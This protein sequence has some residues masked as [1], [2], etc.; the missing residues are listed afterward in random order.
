MHGYAELNTDY[1]GRELF[2]HTI[3]TGHFFRLGREREGG[4][5]VITNKV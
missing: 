5:L 1:K 2:L 3:G 4:A